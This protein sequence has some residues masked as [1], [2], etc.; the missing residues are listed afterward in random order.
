MSRKARSRC[1][2]PAS[3]A[4]RR[5]GFNATPRLPR[6]TAAQAAQ[7][8]HSPSPS[9]I[10]VAHRGASPSSPSSPTVRSARARTA[11]AGSVSQGPVS[12]PG[13]VRCI[14]QAASPTER[15]PRSSCRKRSRTT[16]CKYR[17]S[18][19]PNAAASPSAGD[20]ASLERF[21]SRSSESNWPLSS[22]R[23][24]D[25]NAAPRESVSISAPKN[26]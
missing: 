20:G 4:E 5:R 22:V 7:N 25:A 9:S 11:G 24:A 23:T 2:R 21:H 10:A 1:G 13:S 12:S 17:G 19:H 26:R 14:A 16:P 3:T 18:T 6:S 8:W 15:L